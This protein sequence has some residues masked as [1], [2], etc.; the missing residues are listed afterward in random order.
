MATKTVKTRYSVNSKLAEVLM[1]MQDRIG[2]IASEA[3]RV[4]DEVRYGYQAV[5]E[6]TIA[7]G[8][9]AE[10]ESKLNLSRAQLAAK[11]YTE[12]K[13]IVVDA[14]QKIHQDFADVVKLNQKLNE[15]VGQLESR[16][17]IVSENAHEALAF[18]RNLQ[19]IVAQASSGG[20]INCPHPGGPITDL[21]KGETAKVGS[22]SIA[23]TSKYKP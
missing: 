5:E 12:L 22:G 18:K 8:N 17:S 19:S 2:R 15:R 16:L 14:W 13:K 7:L 9:D 4:V 10:R 23:F 1:K 6:R 11:E 3:A 21:W 20:S